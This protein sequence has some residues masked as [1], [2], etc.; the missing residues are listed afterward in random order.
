VRWPEGQEDPLKNEEEFT[1]GE[2]N[3]MALFGPQGLGALLEDF[4]ELRSKKDKK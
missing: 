4:Q 1:K 3:K 2:I